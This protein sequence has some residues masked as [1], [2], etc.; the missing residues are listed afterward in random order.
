MQE[1]LNEI[2]D[3]LK[4]IE[5][6]L[7]KNKKHPGVLRE[8]QGF[9][10]WLSQYDEE[11]DISEPPVDDP[12]PYVPVAACSMEDMLR[13]QKLHDEWEERQKYRNNFIATDYIV[14]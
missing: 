2:R 10:T 4:N 13:A 14:K 5:S 6:M 9:N 8:A 7:E 11:T 3:I 1:T 12:E